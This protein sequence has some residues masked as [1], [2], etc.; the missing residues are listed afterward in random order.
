VTLEEFPRL[1]LAI[2]GADQVDPDGNLIKGLGGALYREK[3]VARAAHVFVV[4]VDSTKLV[5]TLGVGCPVPVEVVPGS[6]GA[7][8]RSLGTLGARARLRAKGELPYR[9]DNGNLILDAEFGPLSDPGALER[10]IN[11]LPGVLENGIFVGLTSRVLVGE[12]AGVR[13]WVPRRG[14]KTS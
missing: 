11:D 8:E 7:V 5:E 13:D 6:V 10:D 4:I 2:D 3:L 1:D 14:P 9:T 12:P